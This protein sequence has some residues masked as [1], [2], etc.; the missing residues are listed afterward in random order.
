MVRRSSKHLRSRAGSFGSKTI[1]GKDADDVQGKTKAEP[2]TRPQIEAGLIRDY[3]TRHQQC[4]H[5]SSAPSRSSKLP[6]EQLLYENLVQVYASH[7]FLLV[8]L[9]EI[10]PRYRTDAI[11][12]DLFRNVSHI[13]H[14]ALVDSNRYHASTGPFAQN[15][16][17]KSRPLKIYRDIRTRGG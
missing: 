16:R 5:V 17:R 3:I 7:S 12:L 11:S 14:V 15:R 13:S 10:L 6:S 2:R 4:S 1:A 8:Q 9:V